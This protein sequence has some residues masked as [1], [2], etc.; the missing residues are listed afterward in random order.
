MVK[1]SSNSSSF[2]DELFECV[3]IL[4][5]WRFKGFNHLN[6]YRKPNETAEKPITGDFVGNE[7]WK[8]KDKE[9]PELTKDFDQKLKFVVGNVEQVIT[10]L[11][12][13]AQ[14]AFYVKVVVAQGEEKTSD[15]HYIN[16]SMGGRD[17]V[18]KH[19]I[20]S[21]PIHPFSNP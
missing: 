20:H 5:D 14:Y 17:L 19:L 6:I 15:I 21:F 16:V 8:S 4:R 7:D 1:Q 3:T 13:A 2:A 12:P 18:T 10:K 9:R 11:T